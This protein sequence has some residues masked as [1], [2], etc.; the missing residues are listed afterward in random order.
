MSPALKAGLLQINLDMFEGKKIVLGIC[1]SIAAYKAALL[2]RLL[3]KAGAEVKVV[4]TDSAAAFIG[5]LTLATLSKNEVQRAYYQ[6]ETGKWNS[7]VELGLWADAL[8]I[9]PATANTLAKMASGFCDNMLTAVYLSA[10]CPVF[11]APA[12]DLD[13]WK[14]PATQGN[15]DTLILH[16]VKLI[17]PVAG[18]L[19]SGLNGQGRM[20]E[21][22]DILTFLETELF[23][24][25]PLQGKTALVTAGPTYE[26]IDPV[27]FIGNH[28]SGKMGYAIAEELAALGAQ[29]ELVSGPVSLSIRHPQVRTTPVVSGLEMEQAIDQLAAHADIIVMSAAV[30]DYRPAAV[31]QKK[32]KKK[33]AQFSIDLVKTTD[34]LSRLGRLKKDGQV[35][36]GF[37]LETDSEETNA[38][39]KLKTKNLDL[40]VLNSLK[41]QGAGFGFDTNKVTLIDSS[42]KKNIFPLKS[43][44]EVAADVCRAILDVIRQKT[45]S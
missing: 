4:M 2:T 27:R 44:K 35:L 17:N 45:I 13:M 25:G 41:D 28:S 3:V 5:P 11:V 18:E 26:A 37:A 15:I 8:L 43:K 36:V 10:R 23:T 19:A 42:L 7:H 38:L 22:E 6:Q 31:A 20:A 9:A 29:V 30:A 34:I 21:P 24:Q 39:T 40:I 32:I 33:D 16:G 14:H 1:G 12:M